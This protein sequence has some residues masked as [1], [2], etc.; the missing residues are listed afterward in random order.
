MESEG[1]VQTALLA[2]AGREDAHEAD[3]L[4][5]KLGEV[6][7]KALPQPVSKVEVKGFLNRK[8]IGFEAQLGDFNY[9]LIRSS[10]G[11]EPSRTHVVRGIKLKSETLSMRAWLENVSQALEGVAAQNQEAARALHQAFGL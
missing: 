3:W 8:T 10:S 1:W 9:R 2:I 6:L 7:S 4:I 11:I 5:D